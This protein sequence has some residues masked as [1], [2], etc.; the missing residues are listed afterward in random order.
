MTYISQKQHEINRNLYDEEQLDCLRH[1]HSSLDQQYPDEFRRYLDLF[2]TF[3]PKRPYNIKGAYD[4]GFFQ[5]NRRYKHREGNY[6]LYCHP[7]IIARHLDY[8]HWCFLH[9]DHRPT[10][11]FW[12]GMWAPKRSFHKALERR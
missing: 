4:Q 7:G 1:L 11:H 3:V 6:P 12:V 8:Q 2:Y 9:P 10:E 5:Q